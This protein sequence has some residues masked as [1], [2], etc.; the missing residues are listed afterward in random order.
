MTTRRTEQKNTV[1]WLSTVLL[2]GVVLTMVFP[3]G[4][5]AAGTLSGTEIRNRAA[6]DYNVN[7]MPQGQILSQGNDGATGETV[8]VVDNKVDLSMP[9]VGAQSVTPNS[10]ATAV[11][12]TVNNAGN[13][14]QG[15][16]MEI[17]DPGSN[18]FNMTTVDIY[19]DNGT[20][21]GTFDAGDQHYYRF[22]PG[23]GGSFLLPQQRAGD[24]DADGTLNLWV[25][26]AVPSIAT[27]TQQAAYHL[28]ATTL[29]SGT[30]V[31]TANDGG[32]WT[33]M[34]APQA[35]LAD[36]AG[37]VD[38]GLNTPNPGDFPD[39]RFSITITYNVATATLAANKE[40]TVVSDG[41]NSANPKAIPGAVVRYTINVANSGGSDADSVVIRDQIPAYTSYITGSASATNSD[42]AATMTIEY[43]ATGA[44]GDWSAA[45][46]S[47]VNYVRVTHSH[48]L[49]TTGTAQ[50][51]FRVQID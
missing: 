21:A 11:L 13:T 44:D 48:V 15:Y 45:E 27:D 28:I 8:F 23:A 24:A 5:I 22:V 18:D 32:A 9:A 41:F 3:A 17:Q 46:P 40:S 39:G 51:I 47:T 19:L 12:I 36:G 50:L 37:A 43:S 26:A 49:A 20:T 4:A 42:S 33:A 34:G 30:D 16:R 31:E 1:R 14:T 25:V 2:F 35:V 29:N 7:G 38:T 10:T 6:I